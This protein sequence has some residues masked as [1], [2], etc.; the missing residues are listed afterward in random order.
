MFASVLILGPEVIWLGALAV[1]STLVKLTAK[2]VVERGISFAPI[3]FATFVT[4]VFAIVVQFAA[5]FPDSPGVVSSVL[6]VLSAFLV[7]SGSL[8]WT[9]AIPFRQACRATATAAG[10]MLVLVASAFLL[11]GL[12]ALL[13]GQ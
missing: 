5:G 6:Y 9:A 3:G 11:T 1:W 10:V 8:S 12:N 13:T 2:T 7:Y 4:I